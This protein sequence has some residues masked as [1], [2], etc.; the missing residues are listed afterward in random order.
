MRS[1]FAKPKD[2]DKDSLTCLRVTD[3]V[4]PENVAVSSRAGIARMRYPGEIV[5]FT[6]KA[7]KLN[8]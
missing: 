8:T 3:T 6:G 5:Y 7:L 1:G 2:G 4:K